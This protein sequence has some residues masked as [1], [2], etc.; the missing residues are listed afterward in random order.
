MS[1]VPEKN[2]VLLQENPQR[3]VLFPIQHS[4]LWEMYKKHEASFWATAEIDL[5]H[6]QKDWQKLSTDEQHFIKHVLAFFAASDG[7]IVE[8]L[9]CRFLNEVQLPEA[10]C[11]YGFQLMME[12]IHSETYS[13]LIDTYVKDSVEKTNLFHATETLPCI[14]LKAEWVTKWIHS[15]DSFAERLVA[16]AAVEGIFFSGSFCAI[17]WLK[18]RGLM[19]G[20]TFSNELISRDEGL[21]CDFACLLYTTKLQNKLPE[22]RIQE[23]IRAA[24]EIEIQFV[25]TALP[26]SL[27][28][29]NAD[30]MS[31]YIQFVADRLLDA[32]G[33]YKIYGVENP[34]NWMEMISLQGKTNFFEK[35]VG[36]YQ[37]AGVLSG[38]NDV[39]DSAFS[40]DVD[41]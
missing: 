7:I 14:K 22:A 29:I 30:L 12:N 39:P 1:E 11:F 35:R 32:L 2:E 9:A 28:G 21:H 23:I 33:C 37:K 17:F 6:D 20:L 41:F 36:E 13:L 3:F 4:T 24:V 15:S 25:C 34:F 10:R 31:I 5:S 19:H 27:I 38:D 8:N 16:F 18:K 40:S 26:V